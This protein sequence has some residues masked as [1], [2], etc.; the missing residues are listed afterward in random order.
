MYCKKCG[1]EIADD[2]VFCKYCGI[3]L[4]ENKISPENKGVEKKKK[5]YL[6]VTI[7]A[8][9]VITVVA[10]LFSYNYF[11]QEA[12]VAR[13]TAKM[14]REINQEGMKNDYGISEFDQD[15]D[16]EAKKISLYEK[17]L[18]EVKHYE[19]EQSKYKILS[20]LIP[21]GIFCAGSIIIFVLY[22]H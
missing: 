8:V 22:K 11:A 19:I 16:F 12:E 4:S 21:L 14:K 7:I 5:G 1:K 15:F 6:K 2:S 20:I 10:A 13:I 9:I 18:Q 17:G 3:S